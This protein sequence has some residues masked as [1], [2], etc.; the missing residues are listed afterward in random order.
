[1]HQIHSY[2]AIK[3]RKRCVR[4]NFGDNN[5]SLNPLGAVL[6]NVAL[7]I[8]LPIRQE[9]RKA[10]GVSLGFKSTRCVCREHRQRSR[11]GRGL[12]FSQCEHACQYNSG[13]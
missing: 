9:K 8:Y 6:K 5:G 4:V 13:N 12:C 10:A 2:S 11:R 7:P 3:V 1:M